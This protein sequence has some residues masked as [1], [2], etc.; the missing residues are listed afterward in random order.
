MPIK[1]LLF[2][3][4]NILVIAFSAADQRP[5]YVIVEVHK[6]GDTFEVKASYL[7]AMNICNAFAFIM[8]PKNR[9]GILYENQHQKAF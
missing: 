1:Y 6:V 3:F 7:V 5:K 2:C 4:F 9:F 8:V